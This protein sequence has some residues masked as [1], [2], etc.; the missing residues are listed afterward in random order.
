M[1]HMRSYA[2][3][4]CYLA[5]FCIV[6]MCFL[7]AKIRVRKDRIFCISFV[8]VE[9]MCILRRFSHLSSSAF[10][11]F[12]LFREMRSKC[13]QMFALKNANILSLVAGK[14]FEA[15]RCT[16]RALSSVH[17]VFTTRNWIWICIQIQ[18]SDS[19]S[20]ESVLSTRWTNLC[21]ATHICTI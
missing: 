18:I 19:N 6:K 14:S 17:F 10:E 20:G 3:W 9:R 7:P 5:Q 1:F 13:S 2:V 16:T 8:T 21:C 4:F 15:V 12:F 11:N